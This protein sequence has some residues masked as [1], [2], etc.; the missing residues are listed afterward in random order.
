MLLLLCFVDA[1]A[2][3]DDEDIVEA[4]RI[5]V[6]L[7]FLDALLVSAATEVVEVAVRIFM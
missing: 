1:D 3:D 7:I 4:G 6:Y 5:V 2:G